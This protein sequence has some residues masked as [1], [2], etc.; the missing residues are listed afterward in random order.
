MDL[1]SALKTEELVLTLNRLS[2]NETTDS[3]PDLMLSGMDETLMFRTL[4]PAV[5]SSNQ[6]LPI[7]G[8]SSAMPSLLPP[9]NKPA[10]QVSTKNNTWS[11]YPLNL[12]INP[13]SESDH[14]KYIIITSNLS[15]DQ[16]FE[17]ISNFRQ[18]LECRPSSG[19]LKPG[20]QV[21]VSVRIRN[22]DMAPDSICLGVYIENDKIDVMIKIEQN[23][24]PVSKQWN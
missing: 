11:V 17:L 23:F 2:L 4:M 20:D 9:A 7:P 5:T 3:E 21:Q 8:T 10:L 14:T 22:A 18:I 6:M 13:S 1:C 24:R 15:T 12:N 16:S 19:I